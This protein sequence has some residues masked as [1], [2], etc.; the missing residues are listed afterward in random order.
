MNLYMRYLRSFSILFCLFLISCGISKTG[1]ERTGKVLDARTSERKGKDTLLL[2]DPTIFL[3]N[4]TYYLYGTSGSQGFKV[5][6]STD[7]KNWK[8]PVG[9]KDGYALS[10][11]DAYG[12]KGFWAPQVFKHR[13]IYYMAYTANEQIAIATSTSPLGPFTQKV[14]KPLSGTGKQID[15]FVFFDKD[16]KP[17]MYHVKLQE[18]NRI[19]VTPMQDDLSDVLPIASAECIAGTML[20]ENTEK[21]GWPVT[22]GPTVIWHSGKY[23]LIYSANDFR[24]KDYAVGYATSDSPLGP[25]KKYE[26][27]P[28]ISRHQ[29]QHNGPGHGDLFKDKKGKY[30]YVLHV[31]NA[32]STVSP[33]LSAIT[34]IK[35]TK[36]KDSADVIEMDGSGF[37]I[38]TSDNGM[39]AEK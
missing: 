27:N 32:E 14:I 2:A 23:Y 36:K 12:S 13:G 7:L 33:R 4:G 6:Q 5:Y 30:R 24:S 28:V 16:G 22:E 39:V 37:E 3:D 26:G 35:F 21:T 38:L 34:S 18:G 19:F 17:Y 10:R 25:W 15:P 20:W 8:G 1:S 29:V 11:G 31:H 9:V